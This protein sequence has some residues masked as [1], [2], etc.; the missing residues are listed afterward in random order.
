MK[1][2]R[3][4]HQ[5]GS[6]TREAHK[7][8]TIWV[9]RW[10]EKQ[11]DGTRKNHK[12]IIVSVRELRT[13]SQAWAAVD[14]LALNI[15]RPQS[16]PRIVTFGEMVDHYRKHE[17]DCDDSSKAESTRAIYDIFLRA[18]ILPKWQNTPV[19]EMQT[20]QFELWMKTLTTVGESHAT[21]PLAA[22]TRSKV[23]NLLSTVFNQGIRW[24]VATSN[25]I[26]G[27][28]RGSAVC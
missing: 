18:Y 15:N 20:A 12:L 17:L 4:R 11:A 10:S 8:G 7:S 13:E 23:R 9:F 6:L 1:R 26:T 5:R 25:P 22:G 2:T 3:T 14:K 21:R 24:A 27:P 16:R 28:V 19:R